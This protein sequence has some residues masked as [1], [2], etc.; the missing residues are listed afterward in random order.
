MFDRE[1]LNFYSHH[2]IIEPGEVEVSP[3]GDLA[4]S[5]DGG[6]AQWPWTTDDCGLHIGRGVTAEATEDPRCARDGNEDVFLGG[7]SGG[8]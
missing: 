4:R 6:E 7:G 1:G 8:N 2:T 5:G 3:G